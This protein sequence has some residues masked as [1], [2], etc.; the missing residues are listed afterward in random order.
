MA[1]DDPTATPAPEGAI[2]SS[3]DQPRKEELGLVH[4]IEKKLAPT[5][6]RTGKSE[7]ETFG[8]LD[9]RF[10]SLRSRLEVL[11]DVLGDCENVPN[12]LAAAAFTFSETVEELV[13]WHGD[14]QDWHMAH[15][16]TPRAPKEV[17]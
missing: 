11:K 2:M 3:D 8:A 15:E 6:T 9:A 5:A 17:Q 10:M 13:R 12:E 4:E 7:P 14:L 1:T 16:H